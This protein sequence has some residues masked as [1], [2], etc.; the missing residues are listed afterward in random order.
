MSSNSTARDANIGYYYQARYALLLLMKSGSTSEEISIENF[1][2]IDF[3]EN[4]T[5]LELIQTKH[6][7]T[8]KNLSDKS[9]DLWKTIGNWVDGV[10]EGAIKLGKTMLTLVTTSPT[11]IDSA[12]SMLKSKDS[13]DRDVL[14]A[15]KKLKKAGEESENGTVIANYHKFVSLDQL[16]QKKLLEKITIVNN[17]PDIDDVEKDIKEILGIT[18]SG[19][20]VDEIF[21]RIEGWWIGQVIKCLR[22]NQITILKKELVNR[23]ISWRDGLR[24]EDLPTYNENI[25]DEKL[26]QEDKKIYIRQIEEVHLESSIRDAK[27]NYLKAK[28]HRKK[29]MRQNS[30]NLED[31]EKFD[32]T[33]EREWTEKFHYYENFIQNESE[34]DELI[35]YGQKIYAWANFESQDLK[36]KNQSGL[37]FYTKGCFHKLAD[38]VD[39]GWHPNFKEI[40][41]KKK[42]EK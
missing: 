13:K 11:S 17:A 23:I 31:L 21:L 16:D 9:E 7:S 28:I 25:S 6:H 30:A 1:D 2:D 41:S 18:T 4:G 24:Q 35:S 39:I 14:E 36:L 42:E 40:F 34:P 15:L 33:I 26:E 27:I 29:W 22:R 38:D 19:N 37:H 8:P 20:H 3:E 5:P 10:D 32:K 12:A